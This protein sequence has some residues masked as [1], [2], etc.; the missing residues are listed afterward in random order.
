VYLHVLQTDGGE[1]P[2]AINAASL[3]LV[4]AG[5]A[6]R[7]MA[8]ACAAGRVAGETVVDLNYME[9]N[10]G[11]VYLPVAILPKRNKIVLAMMDSKLPLEVFEEV[12]QVAMEA[13]QE[14]Y[15]VLQNEVREH[16]SK[17]LSSRLG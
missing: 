12:L 5:V 8:V 9:Q 3:A 17:V 6:A 13:C 14:V 10:S 16:A 1:L 4:D 15:S 2:C 7:D 11:G